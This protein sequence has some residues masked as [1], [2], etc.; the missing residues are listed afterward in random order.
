M[1]KQAYI[2]KKTLDKKHQS[3][4]LSQ[5]CNRDPSD[6]TLNEMITFNN[7]YFQP[8]SAACTVPV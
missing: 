7:C 2:R 4:V 6:F 5:L 8:V 1:R 3:N